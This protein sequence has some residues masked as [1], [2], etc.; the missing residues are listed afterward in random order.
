VQ[1]WS[2][3]AGDLPEAEEKAQEREKNG[4]SGVHGGGYFAPELVLDVGFLFTYGPSLT[5]LMCGSRVEGHS[6]SYWCLSHART[7]VC[8]DA[9]CCYPA[10]RDGMGSGG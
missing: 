8:C 5:W 6:S 3:P 2:T 10:H 4:T 7:V 1:C 9:P